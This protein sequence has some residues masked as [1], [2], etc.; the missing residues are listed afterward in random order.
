[1]LDFSTYLWYYNGIEMNT[2][3]MSKSL[4][5]NLFFRPEPEGGFT[6]VVPALPGCVSYGRDLNEAQAMA[7][8]AIGAYLKSVRK[9]RG[10]VVSDKNSF[11]S[12]VDVAY[13]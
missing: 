12:S 9:H 8:D 11:I 6:V 4:H 1:M 5:Y 7:T 13:A 2:I 10:D 3:F